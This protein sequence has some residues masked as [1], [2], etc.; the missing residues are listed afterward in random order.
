MRLQVWVVAQLAQGHSDTHFDSPDINPGSVHF[1]KKKCLF[2]PN[3]QD[4]FT[5]VVVAEW[6]AQGYEATLWQSQGLYGFQDGKVV[7]VRSSSLCPHQES[8]ET[9]P[10]KNQGL[11]C[12][13]GFLGF[14]VVPGARL[15]S[16][17]PPCWGL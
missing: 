8:K 12:T 14:Q 1:V 4:G 3:S 7:S 11:T 10:S 15:L 9:N 5:A 13:V 6:L 16:S 17:G 2:S